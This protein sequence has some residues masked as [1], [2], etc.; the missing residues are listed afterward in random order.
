MGSSRSSDRPFPAARRGL[1]PAPS[2][3]GDGPPV[4]PRDVLLRSWPG[5]LFIISAA[6]KLL[7]APW[8]QAGADTPQI[9][10]IVGVA[11]SIGL[12]LSVSYFIWRLIVLTKR[13]LLWRVRRKLILSYIFIGVVPAA[14]ILGFFLVGASTVSMNVSAYMFKDGYDDVV[15]DTELLAQA[16][17]NE[18]GRDPARTSETVQ[19]VQ[20]NGSR[21]YGS[22][23]MAFVPTAVDAANA[24]AAPV[25]VAAGRWEHV[26][27]P[28]EVPA[29][30]SARA[31]GFS[32][33]VAVPRP[34][35]PSQSDP[36]VRAVVPAVNRSRTI[37]Y[38]VADV[39]ITT[40]MLQALQERT[41]VLG[42][43]VQMGD[44]DIDQA[45]PVVGSLSEPSDGSN[46]RFSLF[47]GA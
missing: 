42:G 16:A 12:I 19:R 44:S 24:A 10:E 32:G 8:R 43:D 34:D 36:V 23:S 3:P 6:L 31:G 1:L 22:L 30:L 4:S 17:A 37:G 13:R 47:G 5:R 7:V 45:V 38:V 18:V 11:A 26:R 25:P 15:S 28:M 40:E 20:R 27:A 2:G 9:I 35:E 29:W 33:T 46:E 21:K 41:G 14:L 39:P